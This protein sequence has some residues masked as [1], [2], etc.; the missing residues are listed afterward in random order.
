MNRSRKEQLKEQIEKLDPQEHAQIFAIIKKYTDTY[1]QTQS[2][3]LVSSDNLPP[4]CLEEIDALVHFYLDQRSRM[5]VD[6]AERKAL[7]RR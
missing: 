5:E 3:V 4:K 1:T 2:G 7:E 6:A